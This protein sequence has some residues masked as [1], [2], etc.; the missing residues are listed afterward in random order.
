[1][2]KRAQYREYVASALSFA[3]L[4]VA[5]IVLANYIIDPYEQYGHFPIGYTQARLRSYDAQQLTDGEYD[6][7][8]LGTSRA[9][10]S[11]DGQHDLWGGRAVYNAA[12]LAS[13][14]EETLRVVDYVSEQQ[15]LTTMVYFADFK[16][17][18]DIWSLTE[19]YRLSRYHPDRSTLAALRVNL[20]SLRAAADTVTKINDLPELGDAMLTCLLDPAQRI[21]TDPVPG[22]VLTPENVEQ[23]IEKVQEDREHYLELHPDIRT[24]LEQFPRDHEHCED[25]PS[26]NLVAGRGEQQ[27]SA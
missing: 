21:C 24:Y 14:V 12:L 20:F 7:L 25:G 5:L 2:D 11:I 16:Q 18:R 15:S 27:F 3:I 22:M 8:V 6:A 23:H 13:P 17:Y 10:N 1:M 9:Q 4:L 26:P 19:D